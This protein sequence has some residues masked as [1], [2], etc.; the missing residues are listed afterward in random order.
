MSSTRE[1]QLRENISGYILENYRARPGVRERCD[2]VTAEL[3]A[4]VLA[5][6]LTTSNQ[7]QQAIVDRLGPTNKVQRANRE[8]TKRVRMFVRGF[9]AKHYSRHRVSFN[10]IVDELT[11]QVLSGEFKIA[12]VPKNLADRLG[13]TD[14][15]F[16]AMNR[17]ALSLTEKK[18]A[19]QEGRKVSFVLRNLG[20][21]KCS[22]CGKWI[23]RDAPV[24]VVSE[25]SLR[26]SVT[27]QYYHDTGCGYNYSVAKKASGSFGSKSGG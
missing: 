26:G 17:L 27:V 23:E 2:A 13:P 9:L 5:G 11:S 19:P 7:V 24:V 18:H 25:T 8:N 20:R 22:C 16:Y 4:D 12:D 1:E 15:E 21:K 14:A 3:V 10:L 6:K